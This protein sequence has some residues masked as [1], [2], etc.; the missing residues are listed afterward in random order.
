MPLIHVSDDVARLVAQEK[1]S[2][3]KAWALK[4]VGK[5]LRN[6]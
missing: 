5:A 2:G 3:G 6:N 4:P 1:R